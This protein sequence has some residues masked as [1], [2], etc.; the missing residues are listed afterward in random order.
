MLNRL[1]EIVAKYPHDF[2]PYLFLVISFGF[3]IRQL[4]YLDKG[5]RVLLLFSGIAVLVE[6]LMIV[7]ALLKWNNTFLV[8]FFSLAELFCF[9]AFFYLYINSKRK[10]RVIAALSII[11]FVIYLY[12]FEWSIISNYIIG[13]QRLI[14]IAFA[15]M[16]FQNVLSELK[17]ANIIGHAAFWFSAGLLLFSAGTLFIFLFSTFTLDVENPQNIFDWSWTVT[18]YFSAVFYLFVT[19]S[20]WLNKKE[21]QHGQMNG[22]HA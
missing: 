7:Y 6:S 17:V 14:F 9:S 22:Y 19:V 21:M 20:F 1:L 10:K 12:G 13:I 16:F 15:L 3:G 11:Y 8:N 2:V 4:K 18:Q 5:F